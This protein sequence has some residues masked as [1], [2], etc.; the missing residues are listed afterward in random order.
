M[1]VPLPLSLAQKSVWNFGGWR[2]VRKSKWPKPW[3]EYLR[4]ILCINEEKMKKS[5]FTEGSIH[6]GTCPAFCPLFKYHKMA[7]SIYFLFLSLAKHT[8]LD[9]YSKCRIWIFEFWHFPLVFV[10]LK[11]T[12]LVTLF[13]HKLQVSKNSPKWT[14][15]GIFN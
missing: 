10:L 15:F 9:N 13:D 5:Y 1:G 4:V 7:F 14:I 2:C 11:L 6:T 8:L 3:K 12:I